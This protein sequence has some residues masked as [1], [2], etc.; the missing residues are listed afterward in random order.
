MCL[1]V[2]L[3]SDKC[4]RQQFMPLGLCIEQFFLPF[5]I[6]QQKLLL[7]NQFYI[8]HHILTA[9]KTKTT[10]CIYLLSSTELWVYTFHEP[11][12]THSYGIS[13]GKNRIEE[14]FCTI[15]RD[16]MYTNKRVP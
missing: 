10:K 7:N 14:A 11:I 4:L 16:I 3:V 9:N 2:S 6:I 12:N 15:E 1:L 8:R 5:H 13:Q